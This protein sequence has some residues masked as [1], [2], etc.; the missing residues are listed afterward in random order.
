MIDVRDLSFQYPHAGSSAVKSLSFSVK[1]GEIFGFLGPSGSGKSTTQRIICGLLRGY[2]GAVEVMQEE[3]SQWGTDLYQHIGVGFEL[4]NHYEKLS[5]YENLA[6]FS[7]MYAETESIDVLLEKVGLLKDKHKPVSS[8]SKGMKMRL[9]FSRALLGKPKILFL[10]EPTSGLDPVT[11]ANLKEQIK[12][13]RDLGATIFLTTHNMQDADDL[14]DR[15]GFIVDGELKQLDAPSQMKQRYGKPSIT[16]VYD[17]DSGRVTREFPMHDLGSND[18]F[19]SIIKEKDIRT[20]HS[21]E[22]SLDQVFIEVTGKRL[23]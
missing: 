10:D 8:F 1:E 22:A 18:S 5:A 17:R 7:A 20:I 19:L 16:V 15:V 2:T 3:V 13:L 14:C 11:S 6:L 12:A 4:P 9:N 23:I 21:Q